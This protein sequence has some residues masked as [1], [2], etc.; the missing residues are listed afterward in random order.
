MFRKGY[1]TLYYSYLK[2]NLANEQKTDAL[3]SQKNNGK[4]SLKLP[5]SING[6]GQLFE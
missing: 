3:N 5:K 6:I 1:V 2:L 4:K